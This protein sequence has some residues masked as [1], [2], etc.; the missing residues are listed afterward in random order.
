MFFWII[1]RKKESYWVVDVCIC[2]CVC[3]CLCMA[4]DREI[5]WI[6]NSDL[7]LWDR[8]RSDNRVL[9]AENVLNALHLTSFVIIFPETL[10][11]TKIIRTIQESVVCLWVCFCLCL[12]V[13]CVCMQLNRRAWAISLPSVCLLFLFFILRMG[14]LIIKDFFL[15][16]YIHLYCKVDMHYTRNVRFRIK[17][18]TL[19]QI[20]TSVLIK[21]EFPRIW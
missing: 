17:M 14:N 19:L 1:L 5:P 8:H 10:S 12:Y 4:I 16:L 9:S 11:S 20:A 7:S 3:L 18:C 6:G 15:N 13:V 21:C 2:L